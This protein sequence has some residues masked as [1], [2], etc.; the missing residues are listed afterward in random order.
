[1]TFTLAQL[2]ALLPLLLTATT[3]TVLMLAIAWKRNINVAFA[4]SVGGLNLALLSLLWVKDL[5]PQGVTPLLQIDDF[6]IFY[7]AL[8]L[9]SALACCTARKSA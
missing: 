1:M 4:I 6:A 3:L 2:L 9:V 7:S 5:A 8:V